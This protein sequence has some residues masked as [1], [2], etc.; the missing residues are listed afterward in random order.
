MVS[1]CFWVLRSI[2][3]NENVTPS[4][5]YKQKIPILE[6]SK[7]VFDVNL[8]SQY[9]AEMLEW[10]EKTDYKLLKKNIEILKLIIFMNYS[11]FHNFD[12]LEHPQHIHICSTQRKPTTPI[13]Y[14]CSKIKRRKRI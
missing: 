11:I 12:K 2:W 14:V 6:T 4:M 8:G 3:I 7:H 1:K 9:W 10:T 5:W 13:K